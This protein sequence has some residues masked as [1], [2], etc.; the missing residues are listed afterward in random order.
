LGITSVRAGKSEK[1]YM[2]K[3]ICPVCELF[4]VVLEIEGG[5]VS[6]FCARCESKKLDAVPNT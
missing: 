2:M 1:T 3:I 5:V 4:L 6:Y